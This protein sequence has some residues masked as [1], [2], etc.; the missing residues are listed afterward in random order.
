MIYV[1]QI[2]IIIIYSNEIYTAEENISRHMFHN[3]EKSPRPTAMVTPFVKV[4]VP[5]SAF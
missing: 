3:N 4:A 2:I 1:I 5:T